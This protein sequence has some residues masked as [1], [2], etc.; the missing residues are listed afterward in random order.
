VAGTGKNFLQR[1]IEMGFDILPRGLGGG[2]GGFTVAQPID[3]ADQYAFR[4]MLDDE[5]I[6]IQIEA[7]LGPSDNA[8]VQ[9]VRFQ[10]SRIVAPPFAADHMGAF[11]AIGVNR[12]FVH[13][14]V[15]R[16]QA[17]T[18]AADGGKA[19]GHRFI[20]TRNARP[21]VQG[22]DLQA[23]AAILLAKGGQDQQPALG[24]LD[25]VG[26][27]FAGDQGHPLAD[28]GFETQ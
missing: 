22:L 23:L 8:D 12:Q 3:D 7:W 27:E 25:Q 26:R 9:G 10:R 13:H 5:I 11:A 6:P 4:P 20:D 1:Q 18:E 2:M 19:V 17:I 15:D 24:V 14:A 28:S 16:T 21:M